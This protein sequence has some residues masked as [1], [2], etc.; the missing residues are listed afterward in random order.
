MNNFIEVY[1]N[2]LPKEVCEYI[3]KLYEESPAA[4]YP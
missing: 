4:S 2:A 3:I 1:E